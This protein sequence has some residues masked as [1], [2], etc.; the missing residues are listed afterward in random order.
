VYIYH[1]FLIHLSV[2]G[3]WDYIQ[4]LAIVNGAAINI[5]VWV[6]VL[7][8]GAHSFQYMSRSVIAGSYG[9]SIS[10]FLRSLLTVFHGDCIN[11]HSHQQWIR[12]LFSQCPHQYLLLF[13]LLM[14]AVLIGVK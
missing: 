12:A 10:S 2:V 13:V 14:V 7:Y 8:P 9:R 4:S 6:A 5:G 11:L 3:H 1:N